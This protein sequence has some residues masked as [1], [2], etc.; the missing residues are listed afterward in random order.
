MKTIDYFL[1]F[2]VIFGLM[3]SSCQNKIDN[4]DNL[5]NQ[6]VFIVQFNSNYGSEIP[7]QSVLEGTTVSKPDD[8][9]RNGYTFDAW[10]KE[11]EMTNEWKFDVD[12]VFSDVTLFAKWIQGTD[13]EKA[14]S[15]LYGKWKLY[16]V[17]Y[18]VYGEGTVKRVDCCPFNIIYEFKEKNVLT[19]SCDEEN[20]DARILESGTY[21][22]DVTPPDFVPDP[23]G[24]PP[25]YQVKI[26]DNNYHFSG[27]FMFD[28]QGEFRPGMVFSCYDCNI[29]LKGGLSFFPIRE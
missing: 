7:S 22:Y 10:F 5:N 11:P 27:G 28:C 8:P 23:L 14:N 25:P 1:I 26:D 20:I 13:N 2:A 9:T 21:F 6:S 16:N 18:A 15:K 17:A 3:F 12:L 24:L 19:V 4:P 29:D